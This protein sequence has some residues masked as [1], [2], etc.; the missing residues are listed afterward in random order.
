MVN[1]KPRVAVVIPNWNGIKVIDNCL[2][3][4]RHQ[5]IA[6]QVIV[7]DNYSTDGSSEL[8]ARNY[9]E[10]ELINL[11][12]NTGFT[13]G[14][15]TGIKMAIDLGLDY[16]ALL[17]ND[18]IADKNWLNEL[19]TKAENN[20]EVGI[21]ACKMMRMDKKH[22]DSTGEFYTMWGLPFPRG[23]NE[24]DDN[25]YDNQN[26][27]FGASGGATLYRISMLKEIG[28]FDQDFFAYYE[29]VDLSFRAQLAG[30]K[31]AFEPKSI[32][33]HLV[34]NSSS[35]LKGFTTYQTFKN[36]PLIIYKNVPSKLIYKIVPKFM[37]AYSSFF[38][39]ALLRRQAFSAF[40]GFI[41]SLVLIPKKLIQRHA[42]QKHR[43]ISDEYLISIIVN[44][45]PPGATK[46]SKLRKY[47]LKF[48][49]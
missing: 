1:Q 47:W 7:V 43:Q 3:S 17:N 13:G 44:S 14:V 8:I 18:A 5:T 10:V 39:S 12:K 25:Q 20:L 48:I 21:V 46:L 35:G 4:L 11:T 32:A 42:I 6:S 36:L 16:V 34:G 2:D 41:M 40:K 30:W 22:L 37:L 31:I 26:V 33:Y 19:I 9:P 24:I 23:R 27:L 29:D 28:L 45:L 15:N 38:I 49:G